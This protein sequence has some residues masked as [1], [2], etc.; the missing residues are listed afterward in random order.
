MLCTR[1]DEDASAAGGGHS[2]SSKNNTETAQQ[3][4]KND[5]NDIPFEQLYTAYHRHCSNLAV[6]CGCE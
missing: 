1:A 2:N 6:Q 4:Q 3:K 5:E